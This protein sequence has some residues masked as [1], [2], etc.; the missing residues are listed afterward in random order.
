M[1]FMLEQA[2]WVY[3]RNSYLEWKVWFGLESFCSGVPPITILSWVMGF[4]GLGVV[5][6]WVCETLMVWVLWTCFKTNG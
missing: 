2:Y 3:V 4:G 5:E 1:G 6:R